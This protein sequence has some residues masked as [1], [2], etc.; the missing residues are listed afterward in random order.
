MAVHKAGFKIIALE[1]TDNSVPLYD[2][3]LEGDICLAI[4]AEDHGCP[5]ALLAAADGAA[6]IPMIGRVGSF[7]VAVATAIALADIT[8][9]RDQSALSR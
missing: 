4:G 1:L 8:F 6:Y 7:N 2:I 5:P 9:R 3:S